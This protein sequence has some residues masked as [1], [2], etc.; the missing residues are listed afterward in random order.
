[1]RL[2]RM[3][4][5]RSPGVE[6]AWRPPA[7]ISRNGCAAPP[8][9][10]VR[11]S[12]SHASDPNPMTQERPPSR[13]RNSTARTSAARS[14]QNDRRIA[15]LSEARIYCHDQEDRGTSERRGYWLRER[16]ARHSLLPARSSK[17]T[18]S[19]RTP[20]GISQEC[21]KYPPISVA[22]PVDERPC[23]L[24]GPK[25]PNSFASPTDPG[26]HPD[27]R[28]KGPRRCQ[29][30]HV[31]NSRGGYLHMPSERRPATEPPS[32]ARNWLIRSIHD[33]IVHPRACPRD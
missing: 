32:A 27:S 29:T 15:R 19:D 2:A 26:S 31:L 28:G 3:W 6:T 12:R 23:R 9:A 24:R 4:N 30:Q 22:S 11:K 10:A 17:R 18:H 13:S 25:D 7:R 20:S 1:M 21:T 8:A 16:Q 14:P 33:G 5:S